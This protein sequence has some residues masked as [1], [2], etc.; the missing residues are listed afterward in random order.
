MWKIVDFAINKMLIYYDCAQF[1]TWWVFANPVTYSIDTAC[2][3]QVTLDVY[4][5][6]WY[7]LGK[8]S[9][10]HVGSLSNRQIK[11]CQYFILPIFHITIMKQQI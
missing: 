5:V 8:C 4:Y 9:A 2:L 3:C 6:A 11:I 1:S 10:Y 7:S